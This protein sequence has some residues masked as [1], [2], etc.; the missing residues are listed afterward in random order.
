MAD[1]QLPQ[2]DSVR[3]PQTAEA[4]SLEKV[5]PPSQHPLISLQARAGNQAVARMVQRHGAGE[6]MPLRAAAGGQAREG[7]GSHH[8][9]DR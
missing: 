3:K 1:Y 7:T 9:S 5:S 6:Q 2:Y 8:G 4:R